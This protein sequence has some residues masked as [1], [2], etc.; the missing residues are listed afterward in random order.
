MLLDQKN[1]DIVSIKAC[2]VVIWGHPN[3]ENKD[4]KKITKEEIFSNN[5]FGSW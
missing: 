4:L 2:L 3:M 5:L 1:V